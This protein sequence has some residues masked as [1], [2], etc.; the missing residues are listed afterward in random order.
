[1]KSR[2]ATDCTLRNKSW[3]NAILRYLKQKHGYF[4]ILHMFF[5]LLDHPFLFFFSPLDLVL[6]SPSFTNQINA[7]SFQ[8]LEVSQITHQPHLETPT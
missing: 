5:Q 3:T 6:V 1:M 8:N 4:R 2:T 7:V